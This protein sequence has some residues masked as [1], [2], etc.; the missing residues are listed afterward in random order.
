MQQKSEQAKLIYDL[1]SSIDSKIHESY[2]S[3][4]N[5]IMVGGSSF[6]LRNLIDRATYDI[7]ILGSIPEIIHEF[8][9][10][11]VINNRVNVFESTFGFNY[12]DD[13]EIIFQGKNLKV[14][15]LSIERMCASKC[16]SNRREDDAYEVARRSEMSQEKFEICF[17]D[18]WECAVDA[19]EIFRE[20][21]LQ[22]E[23]VTKQIYKIK[24]WN[25]EESKIKN[26]YRI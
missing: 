5:L 4:V 8:D 23:F 9:E 25:Y 14:Y 16:F 15:S 13:L 17:K 26:L 20:D 24:G 7:D 12:R 22:N 11:N 21:F 1:L 2:N 19:L 18:I 10:Y 3:D 6:I